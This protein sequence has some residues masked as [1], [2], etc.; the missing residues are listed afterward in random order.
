MYLCIESVY[1][2]TSPT[3]QEQVRFV[4]WDEYEAVKAFEVADHDS[5]EDAYRAA[6]DY[7]LAAGVSTPH[8]STSD[9]Q[10]SF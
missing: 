6:R 8:E 3:E 1:R 10:P 5:P 2:W 7:C 9:E 4:V